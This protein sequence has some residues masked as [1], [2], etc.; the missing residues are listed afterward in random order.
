MIYLIRHTKPLISTGI[1]Y[2]QS[3]LDIS[4]SFMDEVGVIRSKLL[5]DDSFTLISSPLQ[6]CKKLAVT[7]CPNKEILLEDRLKELNFGDWENLPWDKI[8]AEE[9]KEWSAN[10]VE[11]AP[12]Q[13][14]SFQGLSNR[15]LEFWN[16]LDLINTNY[17]ITAHDG[18]LR[19]LLAHLLET[20]L[21]KAFTLK[22]NYG[23]V[24]KINFFDLEN[25]RIE[26]IGK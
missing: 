26:F 7:L 12:P 14:E 21:N 22:I 8:P 3:D 24:L 9:L 15:V 10:Y 4:D 5:I 23:E 11:N 16:T 18:V 17:M 2:G 19:V 25:C 13:G 1:C 20:P 6:R